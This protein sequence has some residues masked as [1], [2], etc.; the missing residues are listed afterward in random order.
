METRTVDAGGP[1][2]LADFGGAKERGTTL[3]VHGLGGSHANWLAVGGRLATERR[4]VAVDLPGFGRS[5]LAG[6]SPDVASSRA[7]LAR[8]MDVV[9]PDAPVVLVG[10]SMGGLVSMMEAAERPSRVAGLVL[11]D[12]S[13]PAATARVDREVVL[14]FAAFSLP[15]VGARLLDWRASRTTPEQSV[16]ETMRLCCVDPSRIDP[17][18]LAE[19]HVM[20]RYRRTLPW[21]NEAFLL[22]ARS[23]VGT[24]VRHRSFRALV[25][26]VRAPT[27]V[28][29]GDR[30]RLVPIAA[31]R[32]ACALRPDWSLAVLEDVGH[33][34]Q[35]EAPEAFVDVVERWMSSLRRG[36]AA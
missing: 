36:A 4:V 29:H 20:A 6:R 21:A 13:L 19:H 30:D 3:L 27:L 28:V 24:F 14:N 16:A 26:S 33:V 7:V 8:V 25:R 34:P 2:F 9:S 32:A 12:S 18:V 22:A 23:I 5:P 35:L 11:V 17:G 15:W 31:A 1:V 10:N